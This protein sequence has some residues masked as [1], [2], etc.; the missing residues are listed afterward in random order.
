MTNTHRPLLGSVPRALALAAAL[1]LLLTLAP[2]SI[3][4]AQAPPDSFEGDVETE[5]GDGDVPSRRFAGDDRIETS[6]LIAT[7]DT[8]ED[9]F[10]PAAFSG[11]TVILARS[12]LEFDALA[13]SV[14]GGLED[15]PIVLTPPD[16]DA[17]GGMLNED[18]LA[19]LEEFDD[20]EEIF[21]LGQEAAIGA[22][23]EAELN[24]QFPDVEV[25]RVGGVNR[26]E[27]AALIS[28][29]VA[30]SDDV[31]IARADDAAD[32]LV[33]G[34]IAAEEEI[35]I[36]LTGRS[37]PLDD[38]AE[39]ELERLDPDR[40][41]IAGGNDAI[42]QDTEDDIESITAGA[43]IERVFGDNAFSTAVRFAQLA[44]SEFGFGTDHINLARRD[45]SFDAL[46]LGPH[47]ALDVGGPAP[48]VLTGPD[49]LPDETEEYFT[50]ENVTTNEDL[51]EGIADCRFRS[52]DIAG[53]IAA[54]SEAVE[55][56]SRDLLSDAEGDACVIELTPE[57]ATNLVGETHTVTASVFDNAGDPSDPQRENGETVTVTFELESETGTVDIGGDETGTVTTTDDEVELSETSTATFSFRSD[58]PGRFTVTA[59]VEDSEGNVE[60]ATATKDFVLPNAFGV[61]GVPSAGPVGPEIVEFGPF[62]DEEDRTG[63]VGVN[64]T[65]TLVGADIRSTTGVLYALGDDGE[66]YSVDDDG[67]ATSRGNIN[68]LPRQ[69]G[70]SMEPIEDG[71]DFDL[72]S[73]VGFDFNPSGPNALRIVLNDDGNTN[74][75]VAFMMGGDDATTVNVDGE[76]TYADGD[77]NEG[78][79]PTVTAAGYRNNSELGSG[80]APMMTEL[81]VIDTNLDVLTTQM[82]ANAGTLMTDGPLG[83]DAGDLN[84]FDI[85]SDENDSRVEDGDDAGFA[86]FDVGGQ[87]GIY[88]V[89]LDDGEARFA[90][91]VSPIDDFVGFYIGEGD[92]DAAGAGDQL[93]EGTFTLTASGD[94]VEFDEDGTEIDR[95]PVTGA[96]DG[97]T[98]VGA[99]IRS[100]TGI[101]YALG[102]DGELFSIGADGSSESRG[103]INEN[104]QDGEGD[105]STVMGD[106]DLTGGVGFDFNPIG[107]NALRIVLNDADNTNLRIAFMGGDDATATNVDGELT[108]AGGD[109][110]E[111]SDPAVTA[112]GYRNNSELG[113]GETATATELYVID[114]D[115][116]VLATQMP[117]NAGTLMTD[118][119]LG[120]DAQDVNGFDIL[121]DEN[122]SSVED[123][124]DRAFAVLTEVTG[125][126]GFYEIDLDSGEATLIDTEDDPDVDAIALFVT[127][128]SEFMD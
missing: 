11:D 116:D 44:D 90:V 61:T 22:D 66:L 58:V 39:D 1:L 75:R 4:S 113:S 34:A 79:D 24:E 13:G 71:G 29:R 18:T 96:A 110:N 36:L 30:N 9:P 46:A 84:G 49:D 37:G 10:E 15:A 94:I 119:D 25:T 106:F 124:E 2:L 77:E 99:D 63:I 35:P 33:S 23:I 40:V 118:G 115:R 91:D 123:D 27:T 55:D 73:G 109:E 17:D 68:D 51:G 95:T 5:S 59:S 12:E 48:I 64:D 100:S 92:D 57:S 122:D 76:L 7:D 3:A 41:F 50:G 42:A 28:G 125:G 8:T 108:Y 54:V 114:T 97:A 87:Q 21:L 127:G 19:T 82:P 126:P 43:E 86:L 74:L 60:T 85:V 93:A 38:F 6:G 65:T 16:T 70:E 112:A 32:A 62:G 121:S 89:D 120:L 107:P 105:S 72:S 47:A 101:L 111:G 45:V 88:R 69:D 81:Y 31:I 128:E 67:L 14:L 117:A 56:E 102:D 20:L 83:V 80:E 103:N 52:L 104:V 98:L 78:E 53:G 26:F